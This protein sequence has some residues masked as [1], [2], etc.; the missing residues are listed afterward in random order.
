M[1]NMVKG[2]I[3]QF[4]MVVMARPFGSLRTPTTALKS[5]WA[6]IGKIMAQIR[7]AIG[8]DT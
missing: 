1:A 6:I 8:I 4:T 2:L 3:S 7:M 5:I